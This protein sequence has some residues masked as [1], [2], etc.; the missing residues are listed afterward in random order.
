MDETP[1]KQQNK[2]KETQNQRKR[3]Q[4]FFKKP[5]LTQQNFKDETDINNIVQKYQMTG[6]LPTQNNLPYFGDVSNIPDYQTA[7]NIV[8][9]A[10]QVFGDLPSKIRSRFGND[11]TQLVLFLENPENR[12]EGVKLGLLRGTT[13]ENPQ[14]PLESNPTPT[15]KD[16]KN[17]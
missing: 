2:P 8:Q 10:Q 14:T 16:S 17:A 4:I 13:P 3:V 1:K 12:E 9:E 7:L 15:G 6:I 11:P 5:S